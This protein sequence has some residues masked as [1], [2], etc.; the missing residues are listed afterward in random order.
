MPSHVVIAG[1]GVAGVEALLALR[2]LA[3]DL[4]RITVLSP[5]KDFEIKPLRTA[6][7]FSVDHVRHYD[8]ADL[9]RQR[10]AEFVQDALASVDTEAKRVT[11]AGGDTLGYDVLVLALGARPVAPFAQA[12]TF[13]ADR[14]TGV[15]SGL[16]DDLEQGYSKSVAFVVPPGVS[17]PLPVYELALMT[18]RSVSS[19]GLDA[20]LEIVTPEPEPLA[21]F[22]SHASD[23]LMGL[24]R[25]AGIA[26]HGNVE[27]TSRADLAAERVVTIPNLE[28][29]RIPGV[30]VDGD[31]F[32][33]ID[34]HGRVARATDVYAAGD[35]ADYPVKQGGIACQQADALAEAIAASLGA[36]VEPKPFRPVLRGKLLTGQGSQFMR[37]ELEDEGP[38]GKGRASDFE[39]WFPPT[40]ISGRYLSQ[41]LEFADAADRQVATEEHVEV[42]VP[43]PSPHELGRDALRLD[44]LGRPPVAWR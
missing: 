34:D 35:G 1:G 6:E 21:L 2:D 31:G 11:L 13:G 32:I 25:D 38:G 30:P 41:W 42:D 28:G 12:L 24:L 22:G 19:M 5:E 37:R 14:E 23:A 17:W 36:S 9:C 39:L 44:P 43:L 29:L 18:A 3:E 20:A 7:P 40:K 15:L 10:G 4:A 27:V 33:P 8:L 26:F 16:L